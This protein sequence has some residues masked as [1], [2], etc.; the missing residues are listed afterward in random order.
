MK[1]IKQSKIIND[2]HQHSFD[3]NEFHEEY[4]RIRPAVAADERLTWAIR[5]RMMEAACGLISSTL[6]DTWSQ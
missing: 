6:D 1:D 3:M 5:I 2:L 4:R